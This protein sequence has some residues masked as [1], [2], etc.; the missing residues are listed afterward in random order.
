MSSDQ[1]KSIFITGGGSMGHATA[2]KFAEAGW[3]VGLFDIDEDGLEIIQD[4]LGTENAMSRRLNVTSNDPTH[5][6]Q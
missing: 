5:F 1:R 4:E 6:D 3:F 2:R